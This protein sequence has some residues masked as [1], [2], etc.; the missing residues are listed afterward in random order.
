MKTFK[1]SCGQR[2]WFENYLCLSCGREVGYL[3]HRFEMVVLEENKSYQKC[4][5]WTDHNTCNWLVDHGKDSLY[6]QACRFNKTIPNLE[7]PGNTQYWFRI[8]KAKRRLIYSLMRLE[9]PIVSRAEDP[10]NGLA[11]EFKSDESHPQ[12]HIQSIG[13]G[14]KVLTGHSHG[15]I[16]INV[17]EADDV[18]REKMRVEMMESYRTLLGHFRHESGHYYWNQLINNEVIKNK[19][20]KV[21]GDPDLDYAESINNYY[22]KGPT[23]NWQER[24]ISAYST[25]HPWEDWA[26]T[27][28]HHLHIISTMETA[29]FHGLIPEDKKYIV[30]S[31]IKGNRLHLE[32]IQFEY[33]IDLWIEYSLFLNDLSASMGQKYLYPFTIAKP[34]AEKLQFVHETVAQASKR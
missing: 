27:W 34:V 5:N 22:E 23:P 6:C 2:L 9:L 16:T 17:A 26:E 14:E 13:N 32:Q 10:E 4:K 31:A 21:F 7:I 18:S 28:A 24:Y 1:C 11:F 25:S 30:E 20:K 3:P 12:M 15:T 33:F 29:Y 19:F 8:E